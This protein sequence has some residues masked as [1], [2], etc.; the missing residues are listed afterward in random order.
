M[1]CAPFLG[2]SIQAIIQLFIKNLTLE[3][4]DLYMLGLRGGCPPS[5]EHAPISC[6][7]DKYERKHL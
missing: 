3:Y 7:P 2:Y 4:S 6:K 5:P 1:G